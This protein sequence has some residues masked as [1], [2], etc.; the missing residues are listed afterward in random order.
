MRSVVQFSGQ[1]GRHIANGQKEA[2]FLFVKEA[3]TFVGGYPVY[4][5]EQLRIFAEVA[6]V[7]VYFNEYF[8]GKIIC[9]IVVNY[10]F[11]H[12]PIHPLLVGSHEH[13]EAVV[14]GIGIPDFG[15]ELFVFQG[16]VIETG[17]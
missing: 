11:T 7:A 3:E 10:H 4:P 8:L 6:N 13:I 12:M 2:L 1:F 5:G 15:K 17:S 14:P 16:Q 9:V